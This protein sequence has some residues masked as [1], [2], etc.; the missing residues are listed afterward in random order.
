MK[1]L[2]VFF[3]IACGI[4]SYSQSE[5]DFEA[6][7]KMIMKNDNFIKAVNDVDYELVKTNTEVIKECWAAAANP[8]S[9]R[10]RKQKYYAAPKS[11]RPRSQKYYGTLYYNATLEILRE[12]ETV[13][14]NV[15]CSQIDLYKFE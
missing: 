10:F 8:K 15:L 5:Y 3:F 9:K 13:I 4:N 2:I 1:K 12:I 14:L 7:G 6:I 11:K